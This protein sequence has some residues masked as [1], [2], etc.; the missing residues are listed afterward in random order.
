MIVDDLMRIRDAIE[1]KLTLKEDVTILKM[2]EQ[3]L[4]DALSD[5][6]ERKNKFS[7]PKYRRAA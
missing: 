6:L 5:E 7:F 3:D 1:R 4:L 2:E